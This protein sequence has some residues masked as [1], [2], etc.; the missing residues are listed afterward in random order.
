MKIIEQSGMARL[1]KAIITKIKDGVW[2]PVKAGRDADGNVVEGAVAEGGDTTASGFYAHAE[3]K[4][5]TA[6]GN[7]SHAEGISSLASGTDAHAEG[8]TTIA[9]GVC[10]HAEGRNTDA[11]GVCAHAEGQNTTASGKYSHTEGRF[12]T[13]SGTYTHAQGCFN[14]DNPSFI[15]MIGVGNSAN[16]RNASVI[17]VARTK[18]GVADPTAAKNGYQYLIGVGG[19]QGQAVTADMKSVQEVIDDFEARISLLE[20]SI[21]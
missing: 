17:Y 15:D 5:T 8:S 7:Y 19:Y 9:S 16:K 2:L 11:S 18:S 12:I 6:S 20:N 4:N 13:A 21:S 3:G 10:A 1:V 14:Y